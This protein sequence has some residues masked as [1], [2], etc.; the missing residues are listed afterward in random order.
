MALGKIDDGVCG[1]Y[2]FKIVGK[3]TLHNRLG[4]A[5]KDDDRA[6]IRCEPQKGTCARGAG[7]Y[8]LGCRFSLCLRQS[9]GLPDVDDMGDG[10]VVMRQDHVEPFQRLLQRAWRGERKA[11]SEMAQDV[12]ARVD[13]GTK[14]I[15]IAVVDLWS[16]VRLSFLRDHGADR[17][18]VCANPDCSSPYFLQQ[19]K[20]QQYC[21]HKCAVLIN[22]RHFRERAAAA[23]SQTKK[24]GAKK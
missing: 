17:T 5:A 10:R 21:T 20:G 6:A 8:D 11:I 23:K 13:V 2:L 1:R 7:K 12:K 14:S 24:K 18:K 22:V 19:R 9:M 3:K 15:D 4:N 16:L